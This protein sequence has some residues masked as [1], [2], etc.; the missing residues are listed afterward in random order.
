MGP[1]KRSER[2]VGCVRPPNE[3]LHSRMCDGVRPEPP[4]LGRRAG[5]R[6]RQTASVVLEENRRRGPGEPERDAA[7]RERRLLADSGHEVAE[8]SLEALGD[9]AGKRLDLGSELLV[10]RE[11]TS[12]GGRQ[13][14]DGAVVVGRAQPA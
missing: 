7:L 8:G 11:R 3:R 2:R 14:L 4:E 10:E 6:D 1:K 13:E 12:G 5:K 9:T